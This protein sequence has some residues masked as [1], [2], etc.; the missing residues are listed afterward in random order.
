MSP[1]DDDAIRSVVRR[2][3][4][5]HAA[6]G[7]VI[8]RAAIVAEGAA[9]ASIIAWVIAHAGVPE[10]TVTA[11]PAR[12]LHGS[13]LT[14]R[15]GSQP[16]APRRYLLPAGAALEQQQGERHPSDPVGRQPTRRG[17]MNGIE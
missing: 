13:W 1:V 2:L 6:G 9:S 14:D 10:E 12:G 5:P 3:S 7:T 17:D 15:G 4:R 8:E 16:R 11:E